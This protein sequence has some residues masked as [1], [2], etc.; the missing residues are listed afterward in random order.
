MFAKHMA[1]WGED[2]I[3]VQ[4]RYACVSSLLLEKCLFLAL[5]SLRL[6]EAGSSES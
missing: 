2:A 4:N 1:P 6:A 3:E 5:S